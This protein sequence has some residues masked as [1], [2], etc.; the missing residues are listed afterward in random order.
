MA[1]ILWTILPI[2]GIVVVIAVILVVAR[3]DLHRIK[4]ESSKK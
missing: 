4:L 1:S 2:V 3:N